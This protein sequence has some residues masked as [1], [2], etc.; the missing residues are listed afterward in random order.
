MPASGDRTSGRRRRV[1]ARGPN[2]QRSARPT[3]LTT[4]TSMSRQRTTV[5]RGVASVAALAIVALLGACAQGDAGQASTGSSGDSAAGI[6]QAKEAVAGWAKPLTE[7]PEEPALSKT[8]DLQGK[9]VTII[10]L[11]DNIPVIHGVAVGAQDALQS[12]GATGSICDAKFTPTAVADCLKQAGDQ[13]ADA[14]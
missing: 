5:R 14:V 2:P 13:G 10:P 9:K 4:G 7:Y 8:P 6:A 1:P 12:G 3:A 11:G